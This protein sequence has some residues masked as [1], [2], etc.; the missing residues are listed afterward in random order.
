MAAEST[1]PRHPS[2]PLSIV[3]LV[4][5]ALFAAGIAA[6]IAVAG[7]HYPSPFGSQAEA[8]RYFTDHAA[9]VRLASFL[10]FSSAIPLGIFA[11]TAVSRLRFFGVQAAGTTIALYGGLGA[12]LMLALSALA[13]WVLAQPGVTE[14]ASTV[15]A[16]HLLAF[17][18]GGVGQ[19]ALFGLLVAGVAL[20]GGLHRLLPHWL[21]W[22]GLAV[23]AIAEL[24]VLALLSP[25]F[26]W[27]L[28][29]ARFPGLVWLIATGVKLPKVRAR[30]ARPGVG[31]DRPA[32][33][34]AALSTSE[35]VS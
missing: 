6:P 4:H 7:A 22:F 30:A 34:S 8:A 25:F 16:L 15:R 35:G 14:T 17:A 11:A 24:S 10:Q 28:P 12:S 32:P 26:A 18:T 3:A 33:P 13:S 21:M 31:A 9:A 1:G 29:L 27:M 2:P 20:T 23:A 5:A 19:V